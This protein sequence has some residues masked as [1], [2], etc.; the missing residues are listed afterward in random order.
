MVGKCW[1]FHL[2]HPSASP[3][4]YVCVCV[5]TKP[6]LCDVR[7]FESWWLPHSCATLAGG[8]GRRGGGNLGRTIV[9]RNCAVLRMH[10]S[11]TAPCT[12][13]IVTPSMPLRLQI[14]RSFF[15]RTYICVSV[16]GKMC[17]HKSAR[18]ASSAEHTIVRRAH[19]RWRNFGWRKV[20][21]PYS[22]RKSI[23]RKCVWLSRPFE[24]NKLENVGADYN[25]ISFIQHAIQYIHTNLSLFFLS[26][27]SIPSTGGILFNSFKN[28]YIRLNCDSVRINSC[29]S[30]IRSSG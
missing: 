23:Q 9:V 6:M 20:Q 19:A 5:W 13:C 8:G 27:P 22:T 4:I 15:A 14:V 2:S 28:P 3:C 26:H 1:T 25:L 30:C 21:K 10:L 24:H 17:T 11:C 29:L 18:R 12:L 16:R 7:E